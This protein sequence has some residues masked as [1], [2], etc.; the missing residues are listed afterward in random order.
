M[1]DQTKIHKM[2]QNANTEKHKKALDQL[3]TYFK[4]LPNKD[5]AWQDLHRL[6]QDDDSDVRWDAASALL[7]VF[8]SIPGVSKDQAWQD[9]H[10][11]TLDDHSNVRSNA[12]SAL[13]L[14]FSSI[15][16]AHKDQA[17]QDLIRLIQDDDSNVQ[18]I[19]A[20]RLGSVFI[21]IPYASKDQAWQD[22]H[23]LTQDDDSDVRRGAAS[24]LVSV[25]ISI[26]YASKDQVWQDLIRLTQDDDSQVRVLTNYSLGRVSILKA[27]E[28]V[29]EDEFKNELKNALEFFEKSNAEAIFINPAKF[30]HPFYKSIFSITFEERNVEAEV[31]EYI[32]EAKNAVEGSESKKTL[33]EAVENLENA[34]REVHKSREKG[35]GAWKHD[36]KTYKRYCDRACDLLEITEKDA[37]GATMIIRKGLPI[38][39]QQIKKMIGEIQEK[40][41]VLCKQTR[42][43]LFED[44]GKE[45]NQ[46]SQDLSFIRDPITL[47]K[48]INNLLIALSPICDKVSEKDTE[49]CRFYEIAKQE[50]YIEDKLP[51]MSMILVKFTSQ[52]SDKKVMGGPGI[53]AGRDVIFGNVSG[54]VGIGE[55][56]EQIQ[57]IEQTDLEELRKSLLAFQEQVAHLGLSPNYQNV[58]NGAISAAVIEAEEDKPTLTKIKEGF[59]SALNTIR[60]AGKT[61]QETSEFYNPAKKI[62]KLIGVSLSLL[63]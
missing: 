52:I 45:V 59:E 12:A 14:V 28:A 53:T 25:F 50:S 33:L 11:L 6:T 49:A 60:K 1:V 62:A 30:C 42:E 61:I 26:P 47:E 46:I 36:L 37:P 24:A 8:N 16:D 23:R 3:K 15:P 54:Q 21:S 2:V 43:T 38:I 56:I 20:Y 17:W 32:K 44:L 55:H 13:G 40:A 39:D 9:L 34:L 5:Q 58:V 48:N 63:P 27:T 22:L 35:L 18:F 4:I 41:K 57:T 29:N 31:Q 10:R 7:F 19:T 51:L